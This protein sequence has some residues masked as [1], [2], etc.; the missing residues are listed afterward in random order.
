MRH[1]SNKCSALVILCVMAMAFMS[2]CRKEHTDV[3]S[4]Y[5]TEWF[6]ENQCNH[7]F[8]TDDTGHCVVKLRN[9]DGSASNYF[10]LTYISGRNIVIS[11]MLYNGWRGEM[12]GT[13]DNYVMILH[14]SGEEYVFYK[15]T[16]I[17]N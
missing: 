5:R 1:I 7:V 14:L 15:S 8:F 4:L 2:S 13:I 12:T 16:L 9:D 11:M 6:T 17:G 10:G 3:S